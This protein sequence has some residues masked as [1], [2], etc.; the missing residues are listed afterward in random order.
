MQVAKNTEPFG[1]GGWA[2]VAARAAEGLD[3]GECVAKIADFGLSIH[4]RI[5][6]SHASNAHKGMSAMPVNTI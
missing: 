1:E 5:G 2:A 6:V 3:N 4:L